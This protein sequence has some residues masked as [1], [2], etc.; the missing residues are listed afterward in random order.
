MKGKSTGQDSAGAVTFLA[1]WATDATARVW[2]LR[3]TS[4]PVHVMRHD[5][6]VVSGAWD[7]CGRQLVTGGVDRT[8]RVLHVPSLTETVQL[9]GHGGE[10]SK[11][12]F[13]P[14]GSR[15][16]TAG[17]DGHLRVWDTTTGHCLQVREERGHTSEIFSMAV[18]YE[19]DVLVTGSRDSTCVVWKHRTTEGT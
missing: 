7:N 3:H 15:V 4:K 8:A 13:S 6:E 19:G 14:S 16:F 11:V 18:S 1:S 5:A 9:E 10:V 12:C 2:D 17:E